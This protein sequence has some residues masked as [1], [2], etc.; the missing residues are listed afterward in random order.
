MRAPQHYTPREYQ[1]LA[2]SFLL[3][4]PRAALWAKPGMGKTSIV[5]AMLDLLKLAGSGFFPALVLAPLKVAELVWPA[6]AR[7]WHAFQDLK[8]V[9]ILGSAKQREEALYR[10]GDVYVTNYDNVP[11]LVQRIGTSRWPFKIV[12]ADESTR[13]KNFRLKKQGGVRA[14]ALGEIA[15]K[16]GRW[17]NLSGT[18]ASNGL[19]DLW[20]QTWFQDF[21][22]RLGHSYTDFLQRWFYQNPYSRIVEPRKGAK[23]EIHAKLADITMALLPEDWMD[24]RKPQVIRRDVLLPDEA[25]KVYSKME[26]EFFAEIKLGTEI[27]AMNAAAQSM[28]LLQ[29][30]SG[31]VY[32]SERI[33]HELHDAKLEALE[34]IINECGGEP[35]LV[36]YHFNFERERLLKRFPGSR[37]FKTQQ[38][39]DDWNAGK[40]PVMLIH[41]QSGGHGTNLQHGG[42]IMVFFTHTWDLELRLQVMERIGPVRQMQSGYD[43][44]VMYYDIVAAGTLDVDVLDRLHSK[45]SVQQ[46]LMRARARVRG[47]VIEPTYAD[48]AAELL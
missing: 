12:I 23:E 29:M 11:W 1:R 3:S 22:A 10:R 48:L 14:G 31:A 17:V 39:E 43:R 27:E 21:G 13:L 34:S 45:D 32:D 44:V 5:Y 8:V 15:N 6:E 4:T 19:K 7:K 40:I 35:V 47:D 37:V 42:R 30:A 18:P 9:P 2:T 38:D 26:R 46:A 20:G 25:M 36:V 24:L 28:K 16:T 41:P 33:A